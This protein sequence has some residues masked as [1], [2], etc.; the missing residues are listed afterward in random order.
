MSSS[1]PEGFSF[2]L[3]TTAEPE[4]VSEALLKNAHAVTFPFIRVKLIPDETLDEG[5]LELKINPI[6]HSYIK[7]NFLTDE[8]WVYLPTNVKLGI[9]TYDLV[10]TFNIL[11]ALG[12]IDSPENW[13]KNSRNVLSK[14]LKREKIES[15]KTNPD[16][17]K[18]I[19]EI[20]TALGLID[21]VK[22]N[23]LL[24]L[25]VKDVI[26]SQSMDHNS[27][28]YRLGIAIYHSKRRTNKAIIEKLEDTGTLYLKL[29]ESEIIKKYSKQ[30]APLVDLPAD[31]RI[32]VVKVL[33]SLM[34]AA[35]AYYSETAG[36][37]NE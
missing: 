30:F 23:K 16:G 13:I 8:L 18:I 7:E 5:L 3:G 9:F 37:N 29:S 24:P 17:L 19:E 34:V 12:V 14:S 25:V 27:L 33:F 6:I 15:T 35:Y 32:I 31:A 20:F 4:N 10:T 36:K 28:I 21:D 26:K 11:S 1:I 22:N 2:S